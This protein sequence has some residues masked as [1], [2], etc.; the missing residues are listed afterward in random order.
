MV[1]WLLRPLKNDWGNL[2]SG[3]CPQWGGKKQNLKK[4]SPGSTCLWMTELFWT[5]PGLFLLWLQVLK[6]PTVPTFRAVSLGSAWSQCSTLSTAYI[7]DLIFS[8][9]WLCWSQLSGEKNTI[10]M[11][12]S[13]LS[14]SLFL[15]F[16]LKI[17]SV[18]FW[19]LGSS[20]LLVLFSSW[21][22]R[23]LFS[24]CG[25][26]A[27]HGGGFPCC[28]AKALGYMSFSSFTS[29]DL[30]HRL[31]SCGKWTWSPHVMWDLPRPT[32]EILSPA[33]AV[34]FFTTEPQGSPLL[35]S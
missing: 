35:L 5:E 23:R 28:G 26:W 21:G 27:S 1:F 15:P 7:S 24:S 32:V 30:E 34:R 20:L 25:A 12:V 18:S 14:H 16:F 2:T 10:K 31:S 11:I 9:S 22:E 4:T 17:Y 13:P 6:E 3:K 33:L 19:G 29:Q 8:G